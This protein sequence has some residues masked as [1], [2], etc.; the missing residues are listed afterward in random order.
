MH[1]IGNKFQFVLPTFDSSALSAYYA[2]GASID[3]SVLAAALKARG[4]GADTNRDPAVIPPWEIPSAASEDELLQRIFSSKPIIN[5]KDAL[6]RGGDNDE[7]NELF[8]L[9]GGKDRHMRS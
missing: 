6:I 2:S 5:T 7:L 3:Q 9:D 1:S 4:V 8:T